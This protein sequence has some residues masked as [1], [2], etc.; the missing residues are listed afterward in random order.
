MVGLAGVGGVGAALDGGVGADLGADQR[1]GHLGGGC[2]HKEEDQ[3]DDYQAGGHEVQ[4]P[5]PSRKASGATRL[6]CCARGGA[7]WW[8]RRPRWLDEAGGSTGGDCANERA[9]LSLVRVR[10]H[11]LDAA[12]EGRHRRIRGQAPDA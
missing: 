7:W 9:G 8:W 2:H 6:L 11:R 12:L 10:A 1:D 5:A 4:G 3:P